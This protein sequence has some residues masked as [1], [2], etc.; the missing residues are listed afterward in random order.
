MEYR[1]L[2][3]QIFVSSRERANLTGLTLDSRYIEGVKD[4][5]KYCMGP[6]NIR[7]IYNT[8]PPLWSSRQSSWLQTQRSVFDSRRCQIF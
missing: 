3:V 6:I 2:C 1:L 7:C 4:I 8:G 5:I